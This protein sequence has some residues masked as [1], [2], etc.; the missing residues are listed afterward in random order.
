MVTRGLPLC[1][2]THHTEVTDTPLGGVSSTFPL[3]FRWYIFQPGEAAKQ[4]FADDDRHGAYPPVASP[5][6]GRKRALPLPLRS[7]SP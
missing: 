7:L 4:Q 5:R 6:S 1:R 3:I 2:G